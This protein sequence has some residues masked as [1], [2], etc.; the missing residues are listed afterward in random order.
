VKPHGQLRRSQLLNT[1]GPGALIDLPDHSVLVGGLDHWRWPDHLPARIDEPRLLQKIRL[2]LPDVRELR[3]PPVDPD[4]DEPRSGITVWQ[5]PEW[6][7]TQDILH[8]HPRFGRGR[9]LVHRRLLEK[10]RSCKFSCDGEGWQHRAKALT[11]SNPLIPIGN[12]RFT[13]PPHHSDH[14]KIYRREKSVPR[15]GPEKA[16]GGPGAFRPGLPQGPHRRN[17]LVLFRA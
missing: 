9:R 2:L 16:S 15:R 5:F 12:V 11:S 13:S 3:E 7:I 17:R 4:P 8:T 1:Y 10:N 6:F 14:R